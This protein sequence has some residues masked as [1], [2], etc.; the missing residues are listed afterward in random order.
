M[1]PMSNLRYRAVD[2]DVAEDAAELV[3]QRRVCGW[4]YDNI[5]KYMKGIE[6][7][8]MQYF[9]FF[10]DGTDGSPVIIG[11]GGMDLNGVHEDE[12]MCSHESSTFCAM[13]MFLYP[14]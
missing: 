13:G 8:A 6:A 1:S 12:M 5:A 4:G 14:E 9:I 7:G 11:S 3:K 2:P 10:I